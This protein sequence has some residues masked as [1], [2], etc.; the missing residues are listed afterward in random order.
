MRLLCYRTSASM[1]AQEQLWLC[2]EYVHALSIPGYAEFYIP[3]DRLSFALIIDPLMRH[4]AHK[5]LFR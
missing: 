2:A 1:E 5:D 3:E 4:L